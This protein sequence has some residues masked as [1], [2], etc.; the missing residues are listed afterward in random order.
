MSSS[1]VVDDI[2]RLSRAGIKSED[3]LCIVDMDSSPPYM[4]HRGQLAGELQWAQSK[5]L[6]AGE[7]IDRPGSGL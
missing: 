6:G 1:V 7:R 2:A 5:S 3:L 4:D